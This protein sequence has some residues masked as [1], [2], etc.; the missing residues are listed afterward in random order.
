MTNI[1]C[2]IKPLLVQKGITQEVLFNET[3]INK[4][5][6]K[7]L[8]D[9]TVISYNLAEIEKLCNYFECTIDE[10]LVVEDI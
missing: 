4:K 8:K 3:G 6:I 9:G 1:K 2:R 10:L 7:E 5:R